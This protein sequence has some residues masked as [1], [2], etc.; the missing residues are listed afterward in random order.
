MNVFSFR[1]TKR[2]MRFLRADVPWF[3]LTAG[4]WGHFS[5]TSVRH[6]KASRFGPEHKRVTHT[7]YKNRLVFE[8]RKAQRDAQLRGLLLTEV[9]DCV[10]PTLAGDMELKSAIGKIGDETEQT[11]EVGLPRAIGA[12][13]HVDRTQ[14]NLRQ[15]DRLVAL[16]V[17]GVEGR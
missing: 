13:Q 16:H 5:W 14:I 7:R 10:C 6:P 11:N 1:K 15:A 4:T 8:G 12:D 3:S 17:E 2:K 9:Q